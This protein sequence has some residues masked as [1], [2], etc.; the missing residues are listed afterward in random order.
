M[1]QSISRERLEEIKRKAIDAWNSAKTGATWTQTFYTILSELNITVE[2]PP[3][4][5]I[6]GEEWGRFRQAFMDAEVEDEP[7]VL[8]TIGIA[9]QDEEE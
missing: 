5:V 9:I 3:R 2:E 6:T 7:A 4:L 1:T 8:R